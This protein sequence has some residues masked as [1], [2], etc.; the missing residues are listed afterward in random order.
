MGGAV[1]ECKDIETA[2]FASPEASR[3]LSYFGA[4][5]QADVVGVELSRGILDAAIGTLNALRASV[6]GEQVSLDNWKVLPQGSWWMPVEELY[7]MCQ[8][9]EDTVYSAP[10]RFAKLAPMDKFK[11]WMAVV[12]GGGLLR[13]FL[14][15]GSRFGM[16]PT[17]AKTGT[18]VG[19]FLL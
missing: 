2:M 6:E 12:K 18:A 15:P 7:E 10:E 13:T 8:E 19:Q 3:T 16:L 17:E 4:P 14:A 1:R 5:F 9:I 11:V